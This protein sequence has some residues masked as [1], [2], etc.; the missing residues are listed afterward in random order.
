MAEQLSFFGLEERPKT[1]RYFFAI[2][3]DVAAQACLTQR[4]RLCAER[5]GFRGPAVRPELLHITLHHLGDHGETPAALLDKAR[6]AGDGLRAAPFEVRLDL[7]GGFHQPFV[8]QGREGVEALKV[9]QKTLGEAMAWAGLGR[10]VE[11]TFTPHLTLFYGER[12]PETFP[13]EPVT[14]TVQE[15]VLVHSLIGQSTHRPLA[16]WPLI[17]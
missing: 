4:A 13:I 3:P 8:L 5:Q 9:F 1:N 2:Y 15:L 16:R 10:W 6:Q 17:G 14:W 12:G 7:A 11:K